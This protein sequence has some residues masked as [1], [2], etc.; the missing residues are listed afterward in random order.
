MI[1]VGCLLADSSASESVLIVSETIR[2]QLSV[3]VSTHL[4]GLTIGILKEPTVRVTIK[5]IT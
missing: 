3:I 5:T 1:T 2:Y 4:I